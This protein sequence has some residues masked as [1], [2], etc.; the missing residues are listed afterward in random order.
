[1]SM[2]YYNGL[3]SVEAD[4][5]AAADRIREVLEPVF[6]KQYEEI[7]DLVTSLPSG[8]TWADIRENTFESQEIVD[9]NALDFH[10][11]LY[12][13][14]VS[15]DRSS[16]GFANPMNIMYHITVLPNITLDNPLV[17]VFDKGQLKRKALLLEAAV[18]EDY[19]FRDVN[20]KDE[21]LTEFE[22]NERK[23]AWSILSIDKTPGNVGLTFDPPN[24]KQSYFAV[25]DSK[26]Y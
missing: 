10:S 23:M 13:Q 8:T 19:S 9:A 17:V 2:F 11:V 4:P 15:L 7:Y 18:V 12:N 25:M 24:A 22:W 20:N 14:I 6:L 1:M 26:G 3:K 16:N 5:F 21:R